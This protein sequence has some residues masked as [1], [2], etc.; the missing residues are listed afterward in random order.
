MA[1][2]SIEEAAKRLGSGQPAEPATGSLSV[3]EANKRLAKP[4]TPE[5]PATGPGGFPRGQGMSGAEMKR[6]LGASSATD[7]FQGINAAIADAISSGPD[8][9]RSLLPESLAGSIPKDNARRFFSE[10]GM[11]PEPGK[12][13]ENSTFAAGHMVGATL[14]F[15][16]GGPTGAGVRT[17]GGAAQIAGRGV[18]TL[19][20]AA[21]QGAREVGEAFARKPI[22]T[23]AFEVASAAAAGAGGFEAARRFP[24]SDAAEVV[25]EIVGGLTPA[26]IIAGPGAVAR[27]ALAVG[28]SLPL[29][30]VA[31]DKSAGVVGRLRELSTVR[32]QRGRAQDRVQRAAQDPSGAAS[33]LSEDGDLLP[34]APVTVAQQTGDPGLMALERSVLED[35]D[36]GVIQ[37][38]EQLAEL[39]AFIQR[40]LEMPGRPDS[41]RE[42]FE[43]A[44][45]YQQQLLDGRLR[46]A[47]LNAEDR[48]AALGPQATREEANALARQE[49]DSALA[50]ARQHEGQLYSVLPDDLDLAPGASREVVNRAFE[51]FQRVRTADP[52]IV[53]DFV[54]DA[55]GRIDKDGTFQPGK[56][57]NGASFEELRELRSRAL[58][59]KRAEQ[60]NAAPDR[61]KIRFLD[62]LQESLLA[63]L[64]AAEGQVSGEAGEQLR[65]AL[66]FSR[67][68]NDRFSRGAVG[69]LM[70]R[71][72]RGG[73]AVPPELTLETAL[74]GRG[75]KAGQNLQDILRAVR[76]NPDELLGAA[77]DFIRYRFKDAA[78]RNGQINN[79]AAE[80]FLRSNEQ[81]LAEFPR[82][83]SEF[84]AAM[85]AE[86]ARVLTQRRVEGAAAKLGNPRISKAALFIE[87]GPDKAFRDIA[88]S[89]N[90]AQEA[91]K[92]VNMTKRDA[93]GEALEGLQA[94][95]VNSL[96]ERATTRSVALDGR[97]FISGAALRRGLDDPATKAMAERILTP[98]QRERLQQGLETA[99][100]LDMAG[101][102][103]ASKEGVIGDTPNKA[104]EMALRVGVLRMLSGAGG[105]FGTI[106]VPGMISNRVRDLLRSGIRDPARRLL[107]DA[108]TSDNPEL[109]KALLTDMNTA[110]GQ[111]FVTRRLNAWLATV[112][113]EA[114][115][116]PISSR[117]ERPQQNSGQPTVVTP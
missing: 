76:D 20:A 89:R 10:F 47:A 95:F 6:A 52:E 54:K 19:E 24:E 3:D 17:A 9:F 51:R 81:V 45:A 87:K 77:E 59:A 41:T 117:D 103:K 43:A 27:G 12:E 90:P 91:Q 94:A 114:G 62:D 65:L 33:R 2:L 84:Q 85:K 79:T 30:G 75:P 18:S 44:R 92:L 35:T 28:R 86:D 48:I 69:R 29:S 98:E 102:A 66:N 32:G 73:P 96:L 5:A 93:T 63:D 72:R 71:E 37:R 111:Q 70:G 107:V 108:F 15:L 49:L 99:L 22:R 8:A 83:R 80:N 16:V 14:P 100:R 113:F 1:E 112:A 110:Q 39:N 64:G 36:L 74:G 82:L 7:F 88:A 58:A 78:V 68:L 116:P 57:D 61:R 106:Q 42:A 55:L 115:A 4:K 46:A 109:L 60:A 25:G 26:G 21:R 56:L 11:A 34:G 67:D 38:D 50:V 53:P 31:I 40:S 23:T 97:D 104:M 13:P 101:A 105:G